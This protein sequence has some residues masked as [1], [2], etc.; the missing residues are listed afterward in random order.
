MNIEMRGDYVIE[1]H[2]RLGG[3]P[4]DD[5]PVGSSIIPVW[6]D[7]EVPEEAEFMS[8]LHED[9]EEYSASGHL[10]NIRR[11]YLVERPVN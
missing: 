6:D 4:F 2:L 11:G 8:N 5:L 7:M 10:K 9:T 1:V 3:D